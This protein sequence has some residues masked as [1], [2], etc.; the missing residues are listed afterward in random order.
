[1]Q[2][3]EALIQQLAFVGQWNCRGG[4]MQNGQNGCTSAAMDSVSSRPVNG[5]T[6]CLRWTNTGG[7]SH[8]SGSQQMIPE[9]RLPAHR[10][11]EWDLQGETLLGQ[12][13]QVFRR[14][15][16]HLGRS[17]SRRCHH[18]RRGGTVTGQRWGGRG[19]ATIAGGR[20]QRHI[21]RGSIRTRYVR[22]HQAIAHRLLL[23]G[24]VALEDL[25]DGHHGGCEDNARLAEL[26]QCIVVRRQSGNNRVRG[27]R[28]RL[29]VWR[30]A[31]AD[32]DRG[33]TVI[34]TVCEGNGCTGQ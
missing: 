17:S 1:M 13:G 7:I 27:Q 5:R 4:A 30:T 23:A 32:L 21:I 9:R 8:R 34:G 28:L 2:M 16:D 14:Q 29:V 26:L 3:P 31:A 12:R 10:V 33:I 19:V 15:F 22:L 20:G 25:D 18:S 24:L 6:G 11:I